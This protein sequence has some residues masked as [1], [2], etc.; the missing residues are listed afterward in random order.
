MLPTLKTRVG[1]TT[2]TMADFPQRTKHSKVGSNLKARKRL[3]AADAALL[4]SRL[5]PFRAAERQLQ[6]QQRVILTR[7]VLR[8]A[9]E[10]VR[11][12][13]DLYN[14]AFV[15]AR[16]SGVKIQ[17]ARQRARAS[18]DRALRASTPRFAEY[19]ALLRQHGR[20]HQR[21]VATHL[22]TPQ[23][24]ALDL[25]LGDIL[26]P[27]GVAFQLFRPTYELFDVT[28]VEPPSPDNNS[29]AEPRSGIVVTDIQVHHTFPGVPGVDPFVFNPRRKG[30][31]R[32]S[33]GINFRVPQTGFLTG[34]AVIQNLFNKFVFTAEDRFGFSSADLDAVH[35]IFVTI[36]RSGEIRR[37]ETIVFANGLVARG[38][39]LSFST[40]PIQNS[41][42][43]RISFTTQETFV[44]GEQ[45]QI[46]AGAALFIQTIVNHM[47]GFIRG[48]TV[49]QVK[50][51]SIGTRQQS[52]PG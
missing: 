41:T 32:S 45:I 31:F 16:G 26:L 47:D 46:L 3:A 7:P 25:A 24:A 38:D 13:V 21:L 33:V 42:P 28:P 11:Q 44:K 34:V 15:K 19:E 2:L 35:T 52:L 6:R 43:F 22:L 36:I 12:H 51:L 5:K 23:G 8:N 1:Y 39:D 30:E 20:D 27:G 4:E 10:I 50:S 40:S 9:A 14:Q 29:F 37:F 48:L 17:K 18:I 49:W